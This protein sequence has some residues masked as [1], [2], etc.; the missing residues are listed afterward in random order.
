M[1]TPCGPPCPAL[2]PRPLGSARSPPPGIETP[3]RRQAL[4][5]PRTARARGESREVM[6]QPCPHRA[7]R[8]ASPLRASHSSDGYQHPRFE[9]VSARGFTPQWPPG[10]RLQTLFLPRQG[11]PKTRQGREG[12]TLREDS[13]SSPWTS[14]AA[15]SAG[16]S[17]RAPPL[18]APSETPRPNAAPHP[19]PHHKK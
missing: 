10:R 6:S 17:L 2:A 8:W 19:K 14:A 3:G 4:V 7:G 1:G 12:A 16:P 13:G 11:R 15:E 5:R 18:A 9:E